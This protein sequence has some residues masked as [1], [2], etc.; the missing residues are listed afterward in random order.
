[1]LP[2]LEMA[3]NVLNLPAL[4]RADLLALDAAAR[5]RTLL[6]AEFVDHRRYRK[7][8]AVR[9]SAPPAP[10]PARKL[11]SS[12]ISRT[13]PPPAAPVND[14]RQSPAIQPTP[15]IFEPNL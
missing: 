2:A 1:M 10:D 6:W 11:G 4:V 5:V 13:P 14:V 8:F 7:I 15:I 9:Q 12:I 3:G